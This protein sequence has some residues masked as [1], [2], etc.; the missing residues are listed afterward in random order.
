MIRLDGNR[1]RSLIPAVVP[2]KNR[3]NNVEPVF[4]QRPAN[5]CQKIAYSLAVA[6]RFA[7]A[8]GYT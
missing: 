3:L 4:T 1:I 2:R 5:S 6:A 8:S 7:L